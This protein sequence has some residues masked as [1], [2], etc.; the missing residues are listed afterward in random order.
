MNSVLRPLV[1]LV[2]LAEILF[3]TYSCKEKIS[4]T[5]HE[6]APPETFL[7]VN[8]TTGDTLNS[9]ASIQKLYWDGLDKD[10]FVVGFYY[11]WQ[12]DPDSQDWVWTTERSLTFPLKIAGSD[13]SYIFKIRA[14]DN[15]GASDPTP[16]VQL[17]P[18]KNT[19]PTINWLPVSRI[20]DTT[21]TVASFIWQASDLDGD[22][23]IAY[24]EYALDDTSNWRRIAGYRRNVTLTSDSGLTEGAHVFYIR[25]VDIAQSRSNIIQMPERGS[26][27]VKAPKGDYL[28]IDDFENEAQ[29][30]YPD[31]YYKSMLK[32]VL[33]QIDP[34]LDFDYWN[35]EEQFPASRLQ[36]TE[37]LK[38]FRRIIWYSDLIQETDEHFITAQVAIPEFLNNGGKIIYS[39]QFNQGFGTL[40]SPLEFSPVDSLGK[41]FN[42][43]TMNSVYYPDS[44]GQKE[45]R[46]LFGAELPE[47]KVSKIIVGLMGLKPKPTAIPLYRFN[48][49]KSD[50][51][52]LFILLGRNDNKVKQISDS[53]SVEDA[54]DFVFSGTPLHYLQGNKN[55]DE[56]FKVVF[57]KIFKP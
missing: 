40:G 1:Y 47:L 4:G 14:V 2:I 3:F 34:Q 7:F 42:F 35:I 38:L 43:I 11:T 21:F 33:N 45:V 22:S 50:Q 30:N 31:R 56:F 32:N 5:Y 24:F 28:L 29:S 53:F 17:F 49:P 18:I 52:P 55:L 54:Y 16:A 39:V 13:T 9:T 46:D 6:N 27:Y 36:F 19:P 15:D 10:G 57:E 8:S 41:R 12:A 23:T 37:T 25:A 26:W 44:S 51:D 20:P 48:D